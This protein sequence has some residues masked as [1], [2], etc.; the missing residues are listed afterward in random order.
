MSRSQ[1]LPLDGQRH[2]RMTRRDG[3][4]EASGKTALV[5]VTFLRH[6]LINP[7]LADL[8]SGVL[9]F[10]VFRLSTQTSQSPLGFKAMVGLKPDPYIQ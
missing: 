5:S 7:F 6:P 9:K 1:P 3:N 4:Q 2:S 10:H 8:L